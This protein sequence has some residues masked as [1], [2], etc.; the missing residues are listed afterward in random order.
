MIY[1]KL[2][3]FYILSSVKIAFILRDFSIKSSFKFI[4]LLDILL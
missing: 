4:K 3:E 1:F 2:D